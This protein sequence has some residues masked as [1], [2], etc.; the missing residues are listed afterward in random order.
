[1]TRHALASSAEVARPRVR[2]RH[3]VRLAGLLYLVVTLL[4]GIAATTRPNNLLVWI[5]GIALGSILASGI[6]SGFMLMRLR[7]TRLDPRRA[8]AGEA[9]PL[10][11]EVRNE[12]RW[13]SAF[14][15]IV[16]EHPTG[17]LDGW[18][19]ATSPAEARILHVGPGEQ[20]HAESWIEPTRRGRMTF[21]EVAV[22]SR[23]PFGLLEKVVRF[24]LPGEV[25]VHPRRHPV[26]PG[27]LE[28]LRGELSGG[29]DQIARV[30]GGDDFHGV[31]E[32]RPGDSLRSIAWKRLAGLDRLATIERSRTGPPRLLLRLDLRTA[33]A[34]LVV[35]PQGPSARE[36]EE[37]AISLVASLATGAMRE[38]FEVGLD[39]LGL[40][41]PPRP[42]RGGHW[43]LE[44]L[45]GTLAGLDLDAP[46]SGGGGAAPPP[47]ARV[48]QVSVEA[49]RSRGELGGDGRWRL[50]AT[51]FDRLLVVDEA[52]DAR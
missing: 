32:Y 13:W 33:T 49:T 10:R 16:R 27:V 23:F 3:R 40:D 51:Q 20:V 4:L 29:L 2:Y 46:R 38:G 21:R 19:H 11:Y 34:R 35:D 42:I 1:M 52:G 39:V 9:A 45:L 24:E 28:G 47:T 48:L 26:R 17:R 6:V 8:T 44:R 7:V 5:F 18:E 50:A 25:L 31:R 36:M 43:H 12:S 22:S 37:R 15:L 14:G 30:G 41:A